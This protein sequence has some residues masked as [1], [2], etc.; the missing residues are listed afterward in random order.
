MG[1]SQYNEYEICVCC[2]KQLD[3]LQM[4]PITNREYYIIGAGQLCLECYCSLNGSGAGGSHI[5]SDSQMEYL[6]DRCQE[7]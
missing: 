2:G 1:K 3:I 5:I 4:T 6:I 7:E